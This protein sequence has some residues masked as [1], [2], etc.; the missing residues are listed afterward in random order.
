MWF[1][2][3]SLMWWTVQAEDLTFVP[4]NKEFLDRLRN[5]TY[6]NRYATP[7]QY[8]GEYVPSELARKQKGL[9]LITHLC[10]CD[11]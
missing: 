3:Q 11:T 7:T 2:L 10:I 8:D 5:E 1:L 4:L 6:Y 9:S